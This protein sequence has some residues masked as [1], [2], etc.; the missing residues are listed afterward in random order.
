VRVF[1]PILMSRICRYAL[2][3]ASSFG[4]FAGGSVRQPFSAGVTC[5]NGRAWPLQPIF[6]ARIWRPADTC[7]ARCCGRRKNSGSKPK[8]SGGVAL[9]WNGEDWQGQSEEEK[10]A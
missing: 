1:D 7:P 3:L 4:S 2:S 5:W 10:A 8:R 6:A 9:N